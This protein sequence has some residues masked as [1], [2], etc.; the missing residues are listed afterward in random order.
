MRFTAGVLEY[1]TENLLAGRA[2]RCKREGHQPQADSD[3]L[4]LIMRFTAG[5][6]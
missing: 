1:I 4:L 2:S 5:V 3:I 6:L